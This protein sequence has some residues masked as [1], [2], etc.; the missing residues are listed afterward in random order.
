[1][2]PFIY[3]LS[4]PRRPDYIRY[5]GMSV[6]SSRPYDHVKAARKSKRKCHLYSWINLL[7]LEGYEP[8]I[9]LIEQCSEGT[10]RAELGERERHHISKLRKDGHALTN[11][12]DGADGGPVFKGRKH[13]EE[14]RARM[15]E[16]W[17]TRT[18]HLQTPETRKKI[19][20]G[21]RGKKRSAE[22]R[23]KYSEA[24]KGHVPWNKGKQFVPRRTT[25]KRI[26]RQVTPEII[27]E[28]RASWPQESTRAIA[29]RLNI[30]ASSAY[31]IASNRRWTD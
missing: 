4:D 7:L 14:T 5:V 13:T 21:N 1:M 16:A 22:V 28:I 12:T 19:G 18:Q 8:A 17:K 29:K 9:S 20:D 15:R 3:A 2:A 11:M 27:R 25:P 10:T 23:A 6:H 26:Y 24:Q 31:F 30:S